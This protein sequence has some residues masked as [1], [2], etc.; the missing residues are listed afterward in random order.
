MA[1]DPKYKVTMSAPSHEAVDYVPKS[2]L[3]AYVADAK[4]R[5][6]YNAVTVSTEPDYGPGGPDGPTV[7]PAHLEV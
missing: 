6:G 3:D 4:Q 5:W 1:D 7:V 2:I